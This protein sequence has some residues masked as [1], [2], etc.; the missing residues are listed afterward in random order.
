[1][2]GDGLCSIFASDCHHPGD[3]MLASFEEV[4]RAGSG[5]SAWDTL[6]RVNPALILENEA[7]PAR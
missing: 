2:I 5:A 6:C 4:V 7:L 3:R 1:L